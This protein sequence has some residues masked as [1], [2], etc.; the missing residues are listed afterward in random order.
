[1]RRRLLL[2]VL[3]L[4]AACADRPAAP[5]LSFINGPEDPGPIVLRSSNDGFFLLFNTDRT[6][7]LASLI[8]LPDPPGDVIPCGGTQTLEPADLQLVFHENGA[9]NQL[10]MGRQVRA[11]VYERASFVAAL[12]AGGLCGAIASQVPIAQGLVDFTAHDNDTF[13]SGTRTNA[14]GWSAN[15]T[16]VRVADGATLQLRVQSRGAV[17]PDGAVRH[18]LSR[19]TATP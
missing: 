1:M 19:I 5:S 14:F 17:A 2:A 15:G 4:V 3:A 10:L 11:H 13:F 18:V 12:I 7:N 8:R 9:I 6:T 16:V